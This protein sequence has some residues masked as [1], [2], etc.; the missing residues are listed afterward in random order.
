[1]ASS[2]SSLN[3]IAWT[4]FSDTTLTATQITALKTEANSDT[5]AATILADADLF[6]GANAPTTYGGLI[7]SIPHQTIPS[8]SPLIPNT[9]YYPQ[10]ANGD[11]AL[12]YI[13][14]NY[15]TGYPA[16][17]YYNASTN[18]MEWA[19]RNAAGVYYTTPETATQLIFSGFQLKTS[20]NANPLSLALINSALGT[21]FTATTPFAIGDLKTVIT[22]L[23]NKSATNLSRLSA[24]DGGGIQYIKGEWFANGQKLKFLDLYLA[25]R[26]NTLH[27]IQTAS[28][29]LLNQIQ[30]RN[31]LLKEANEFLSQIAAVTPADSTSTVSRAKLGEINTNFIAKY[32]YNPY[33]AFCPNTDKNTFIPA[34]D[35]GTFKQTQ[36]ENCATEIKGYI[37]SQ[38]TNNESDQ[39]YLQEMTNK[40]SE[41]TDAISNMIKSMGQNGTSVARNLGA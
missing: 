11:T 27:N 36:M 16:V 30:K 21:N 29:N 17:S 20:P 3:S 14:T 31:K 41:T 33:T 15:P 26:V 22:A 24:K 12:D 28:A 34:G 37:S 9:V 38:Q 6:S 1:M 13:K 4:D 18:R 7:N 32:G 35:N 10:F 19:V 25:V 39:A 2:I 5:L 8:G 40:R 23:Q